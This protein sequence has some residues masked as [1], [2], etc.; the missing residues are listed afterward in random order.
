MGFLKLVLGG[1][2][3]LGGMI[4]F[5]LGLLATCDLLGDDYSRRL[6]DSYGL[7][8]AR[9]SPALHQHFD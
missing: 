6:L 8:E 5:G 3:V 1:I 2:F 7:Y 9:L 4:A